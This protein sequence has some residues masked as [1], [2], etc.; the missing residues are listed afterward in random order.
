MLKNDGTLPLNLNQSTKVAMIGFWADAPDK[1]SGGYSGTPFFQ[2]SPAYAARQ[3]G[4]NVTIATGPI[5]QTSGATDNWTANA[6]HSAETADYILYFGGLDTSAAGETK[7]R[8]TIEWPTAQLALIRSLSNLGKPLVIVQL[9]DQ[10]DD[11][12]ILEMP[13]VNSIIWANWPGQDGGVAV[14][15]LISGEKSPAGRLPVT[16]YPAKYTSEVPMTEMNL[17]PSDISPGRTYRWYPASIKAFGFSLH[18]TSFEPKF[19]SLM[20]QNFSI[21]ELLK[22]CHNTYLDTCSFPTLSVQVTNTSNRT[23]DYVTLAFLSGQYGPKP[24]PI[25]TLAAY[26][27][28]HNIAPGSNKIANLTWTLGDLTRHDETGSTVLYPGTYVV[29][30]DEPLLITMNFTLTGEAAVLDKWPIPS[31]G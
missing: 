22:S 2:H 13:G 25:K 29:T 9:G 8:T 6:L 5:L 11:T 17:R 7:D 18:Y 28:L 19:T 21:G 16:Q 4:L 12:P 23:S 26:S 15:K 10:V 20:S 1:L 27:R 30:I 31:P 14:M 24:Y 3:M